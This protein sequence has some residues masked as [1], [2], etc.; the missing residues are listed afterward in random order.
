ML[1]ASFWNTSLHADHFLLFTPLPAKW[2]KVKAQLKKE[3]FLRFLFNPSGRK[4]PMVQSIREHVRVT[5]RVDAISESG[6]AFFYDIINTPTKNVLL[7]FS[8]KLVFHYV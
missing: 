7:L 2:V 4:M 8:I 3:P 1:V 5:F 6:A